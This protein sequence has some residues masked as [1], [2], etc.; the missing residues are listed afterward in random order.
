[1]TP[2]KNTYNILIYQP[3]YR[4]EVIFIT[5]LLL[6]LFMRNKDTA[7]YRLKYGNFSSFVGIICNILLAVLKGTAGI[8]FNSVAILAD[9]VNN[10]SDAGTS[11]ISLIGFIVSEKPADEDHPYGHARVEYISCMMVAFVILMLGLSLLKTS[12]EGIINPKPVSTGLISIAVLV[13]S[14]IIKLWLSGFFKKM[15]K[16]INSSVLYAT[17]K[18]SL[19]DVISTSAV[20]LTTTIAAFTDINLD[21]Y[22]GCLVSFFILYAGYGVLKDTMNNLLGAMPDSELISKI[23]DKLYSYEGVYGLHDLVVHSYGP[24]KY[25]ATV[26]VEVPDNI[27]IL[28]SHDMI[29]NIE[30]DFLNELNINLVIHLDPVITDDEETNKMKNLVIETVKTIDEK[31]TV[32]DF[33]MVKGETHSNLIFDVAVPACCKRSAKELINEISKKINSYNMNLFA[34]VTIDRSYISER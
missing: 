19:N 4:K 11:A 31:F 14:I 2:P 5:N 12:V 23:T 22:A 6:K 7:T 24:D 16:M 8:L 27:D 30:R 18:D 1:M 32:H 34:V 10:L 21:S 13:V 17:A 29:D 33:R 28:I 20:L 15:G 3:D 26:H 25:F 9:A